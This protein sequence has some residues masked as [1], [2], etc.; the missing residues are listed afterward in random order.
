MNIKKLHEEIEKLMED[1]M[2]QFRGT[3]KETHDILQKLADEYGDLTIP[4]FIDKL[5]QAEQNGEEI[6]DE[7]L[8]EAKLDWFP[9][10]DNLLKSLQK[11]IRALKL[12]VVWDGKEEDSHTYENIKFQC[13]REA[14]DAL[15]GW[16]YP[17][18]PASMGYNHDVDGFFDIE[19]DRVEKHR[20]VD[21]YRKRLKVTV[22][23]P[24]CYFK[25]EI[26]S[27]WKS[28]VAY[29]NVNKK[30]IGYCFETLIDIE[31]YDQEQVIKDVLFLFKQNSIET[32][33]KLKQPQIDFENATREFE[34]LAKAR[35]A[36][37]AN[38]N[39]KNT[40]VKQAL[41]KSSVAKKI[42]ALQNPTP[43]QLARILA[44]IE[45]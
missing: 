34:E 36:A 19:F 35:R 25:A 4:E 44:A 23:A 27:T 22:P 42:Q 24:L 2:L 43:E 6:L 41:S 11:K 40:T 28:Y 9:L 1:E 3:N 30:P 13:V 18:I 20:A 14:L 7:S 15:H 45:E 39:A 37:R 5:I 31:D 17:P 38:K 33:Q 21:P 10:E 29:E 26:P 16:F 32:Q 8:N 12:P